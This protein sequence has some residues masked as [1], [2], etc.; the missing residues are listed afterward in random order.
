MEAATQRALKLAPVAPIGIGLWAGAIAIAPTWQ[1][2]IALLLPAIVCPILCWT[3][4]SSTFWIRLFMVSAILL[5]PIA[6]EVGGSYP[7]PS[8][9]CLLLGLAAGLLRPRFWKNV[10]ASLAI[11]LA[12]FLVSL[13]LSIGFGAIYS[14]P[15][16]AVGSLIRIVLLFA[17]PYLLI[18]AITE[19]PQSNPGLTEARFLFAIAFAAATF[20][21]FD[22]YFQFPAPAGFSDQFVWLDEGVFRRAQG[23]FYEASTLGNYC[24]FFLLM[25]AVALFRPRAERPYSTPVLLGGGV[26]LAIAL[27]FSYSRASLLNLGTSV[28]VAAWLRGAKVRRG[29]IFM[30]VCAAIGIATVNVL[31]PSFASSYWIR[32]AASVQYFWSS[33]EGVLSGR[34][35]S[36]R[37]LLEFLA[38][39]PW[40]AIFGIGYKTLPYSEYLGKSVIGDNTYLTLLVETGIV[41]LGSFLFLN[42]S[43]LRYA[44]KAAKS[45][46]VRAQ[47]YGSW[48][49][50]FWI[51]ELIQMLSGDL[52]TYWRILPV[53]FWV[54]AIAVSEWKRSTGEAIPHWQMTEDPSDLRSNAASR[55]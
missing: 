4:F 47:F 13:L 18:Y 12:A 5:P 14:G 3:L 26:V 31:F 55:F 15:F 39:E 10:P 51:G 37:T 35:A 54:L 52:I 25:I 28:M 23:L 17:G 53:Y 50:C 38:R 24:S 36:W 2:R 9:L 46:G 48:I 11:G 40:S 43:I 1:L 29:L 19:Q 33:P 41:G 6:I 34:L 16:V 42:Y 22:F 30:V 7:H 44:W 20:A 8:I 27:V 45:P 21:C 49:F 32:L